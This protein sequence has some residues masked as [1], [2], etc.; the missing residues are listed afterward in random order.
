MFFTWGLAAALAIGPVTLGGAEATADSQVSSL[1]PDALAVPPEVDF[2]I[3]NE[4][5][6]AQLANAPV[7]PISAAKPVP[8]QMKPS[9]PVAEVIKLA[10]AGTAESVLLAYV[11]NSPGLFNL[12]ADQIIYLNDIG[13]PS[14]VVTAMLQRD[15]QMKQNGPTPPAPATVSPPEPVPAP[16]P[17]PPP[18]E[19]AGVPP[20]EMEPPPEGTDTDFYNS[21][22][23]YGTWISVGGYGPCWQPTVCSINPWWH[24]YCDGGHWVYTDCGWYWLS[25]YSW[26]WAP[27]H[28][29]RW[30]HHHNLGWCWAPDRVWGPSWVCWRYT[31]QHCG[32]APL[33][34]GAGC[35]PGVGL[36]YCGQPAWAGCNFGLGASAFTFV[37]WHSFS[38]RHLQPAAL[39]A[40]QA[41]QVFPHTVMAQ[42][43]TRGNNGVVNLGLAP[44]RV[45]AATQAPVRA[46]ALRDAHGFHGGSGRA[47][48]Y[49]GRTGTMSVF[50]PHLASPALNVNPPALRPSPPAAPTAPA[51]TVAPRRAEGLRT[52]PTT[53]VSAGNAGA[54]TPAPLILRGRQEVS[55]PDAHWRDQ[56]PPHSLIV[57]GQKDTRAVASVPPVSPSAS[58]AQANLAG[59]D[60]SAP[61]NFR[62]STPANANSNTR[63]G[64]S[65]YPWLAERQTRAVDSQSDSPR[66]A[67][68]L[69]A[70]ANNSPFQRPGRSASSDAPWRAS[71]PAAV[72]QRPLPTV[73]GSSSRA[74]VTD[75]R[76]A[77]SAPSA[78]AA[79]STAPA[80]SSSGGRANSSPGRGSR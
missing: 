27:F 30:F 24:P 52:T 38:D 37:S 54:S 10:N 71:A 3:T 20:P 62:S 29:G 49:N 23:P 55:A 25:D 70:R 79:S 61:G 33:P 32:W 26:G 35:Q 56:V 6:E 19:S 65:P 36:T 12:E 41:A 4:T 15:L 74:V 66:P 76:S 18:T 5:A 28:Y 34:P 21:L 47:E 53:A 57:V 17:E 39:P 22:A 46:V 77:P 45:A 8:P 64:P 9:G 11:T 51:S 44:D 58:S 31:N 43:V 68:A 78:A 40:Q 72:P 60:P 2:G 73:S 69:D 42:G 63:P 50:R 75:S 1:P 16:I 67:N 80:T 14:S 7:T 59:T 13:V 48:Q